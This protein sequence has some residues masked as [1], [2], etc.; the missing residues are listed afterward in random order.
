MKHVFLFLMGICLMI[1]LP[2]LAGLFMIFA[3]AAMI[4]GE[5]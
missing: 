3:V 2:G 5:E 4:F 1:G